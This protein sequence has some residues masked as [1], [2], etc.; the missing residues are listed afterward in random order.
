MYG[1][2]EKCLTDAFVELCGRKPIQKITVQDIVEAAGVSKQTFYNYFRDKQD[3]MNSVYQVEIDRTYAQLY[4][5]PYG[6][7]EA[8]EGAKATLERFADLK[9]YY[10]AIA[11]YETQ[12]SF[13]DFYIQST[14]EFYERTVQTALGTS[15]LDDHVRRLIMF[16]C[17]GSSYILFDWIK[18][19]MLEPPQAV[20]E[21][22][23]GCL[24]QELKD[25]I[26]R[27]RLAAGYGCAG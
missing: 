23:I 24:S 7:S 10:T 19:G 14:Y 18:R 8:L 2:I 27:A 16:N 6:L 3:L 25:L 11:A 4:S 9:D 15:E 1:V 5:R 13:R 20:A 12:N 17:T 22:I 26:E 21:E